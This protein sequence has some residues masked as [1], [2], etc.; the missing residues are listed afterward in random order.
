MA[1]PSNA[2]PKEFVLIDEAQTATGDFF[3]IHV[4]AAADANLTVKGS[5]IRVY[6]AIDGAS[7]AEVV[8]YINPDTGEPFPGVVDGSPADLA[9]G[10][11]AGFY[12]RVSTVD[13]VIPCVAGN[14]IYGN[15]NSITGEASDKIIAYLK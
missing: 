10:K 14:T 2:F 4:L 5:G 6:V 12:E 15:F 8:K 1:H 7:A 13:T 9:D 3:A 11:P